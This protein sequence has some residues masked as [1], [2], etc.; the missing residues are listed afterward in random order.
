MGLNMQS[1]LATAI[2]LDWLSTHSKERNDYPDLGR[3]EW[4]IVRSV[5]QMPADR[6]NVHQLAIYLNVPRTS[7]NRALRKLKSRG[8]LQA[9]RSERD[10]RMNLFTLTSNGMASAKHDPIVRVAKLIEWLPKEEQAR[11][12]R[13]IRTMAFRVVASLEG[14]NGEASSAGGR[15]R[16]R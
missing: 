10:K 15:P 11:F 5:K 7:V 8:L 2:L 4:S 1:E 14:H 13:S 9:V 3:L 6:C 16:G 12:E